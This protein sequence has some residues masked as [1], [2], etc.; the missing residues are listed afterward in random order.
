MKSLKCKGST[1]LELVIAIGIA[2]VVITAIMVLATGSVRNSSFAKNKT[3]A[4]RFSQETLEWA[5]S[6]KEKNWFT[7]FSK[8]GNGAVWCLPTLSWPGNSG[9]C[10]SDQFI[11]GTTIFKRELTLTNKDLDSDSEEDEVEAV[12]VVYWE[13]GGRTHKASSTTQFANLK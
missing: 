3:E 7:F 8:S 13:D 5:R 10:T 9:Q 4:T 1:L 11:S 2:T 12:A 6:E